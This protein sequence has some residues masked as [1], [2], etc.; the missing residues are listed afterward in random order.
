MALGNGN[1][2]S[3]GGTNGTN[4]FSA[5]QLYNPG[6]GT[7]TPTGHMTA[8]RAEFAAVV[9][10]SGKVLVEGGIGPGLAIYNSAELYDPSTGKWSPAGTMVQS[11]YGHTATLLPNGEVLVTGGCSAVY[12]ASVTAV[13]EIYNPATNSWKGVASLHTPRYGHA[14][15]LLSNGKVLVVGGPSGSSLKSTEVYNPTANTWTS[16]PT[17][18]APRFQC[19]ATALSNGK[20]LIA[21]GYAPYYAYNTVELYDPAK[22]TLAVTTTL[23]KGRYAHTATALPNNTVLIAAG[24]SIRSCGKGGHCPYALNTAE[25]YDYNVSPP[26]FTFTAGNL[27]VARALHAATLMPNNDVLVTAGCTATYCNTSTAVS[28]IYTPLTLSISSY[29]LGFGLE[30]KGGTTAPQPLKVTNVSHSAVKFTGITASANFAQTNNCP[31]SPHSLAPGASCSI[32]VTFKPAALGLLNGTITVSDT[33]LGSPAQTVALTGTGEQYAIT[34][35]PNPLPLPSIRPGSGST[36]ATATVTNDGSGPV[37]IS[38]ISITPANKVFTQTNNCPS[39]LP[40]QGTCTIQ[41][42]FTPPDSIP[43]KATLRIFDN[44]PGSP[45]LLTLTGTGLD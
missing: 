12:C 40:V 37:N 36:S 23:N 17:S 19:T 15:A 8:A 11:R 10:H 30:E 3:A 44:A 29:S 25:I 26:T 4:F 33:S 14:A 9:L 20:V 42:V 13:S 6:K 38:S 43:Y 28:E 22:N 2:L 34:A 39:T 16:G 35:A 5:A 24:E 1:V 21:G 45:H 32:S 27:N 7:W 18:S 31:S 41:V